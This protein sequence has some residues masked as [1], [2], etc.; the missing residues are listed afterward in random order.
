MLSNLQDA[1][2]RHGQEEA[3]DVEHLGLLHQAPDGLERVVVG[4]KVSKV[5]WWV[6]GWWVM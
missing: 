3:R 2:G 6:R 4:G 1:G 5:G